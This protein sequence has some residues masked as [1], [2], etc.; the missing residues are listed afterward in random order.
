[1]TKDE[2]IKEMYLIV[3][4]K[5]TKEQLKLV[6]NQDYIMLVDKIMN[7]EVKIA[8]MKNMSKD[9]L[10]DMLIGQMRLDV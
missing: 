6:K 3:D 9:E 10:F 2:T 4:E 7:Y 5:L 8:D 1:M